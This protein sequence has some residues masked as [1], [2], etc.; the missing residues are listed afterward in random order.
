MFMQFQTELSKHH[1]VASALRGHIIRAMLNH[2]PMSENV[3]NKS[4]SVV[5]FIL[6]VV[7]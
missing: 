3:Q 1:S 4:N 6:C 2:S 7:V 5:K